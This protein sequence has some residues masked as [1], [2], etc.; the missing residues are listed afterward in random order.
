MKK[1]NHRKLKGIL[2]VFFIYFI[3][4][5]YFAHETLQMFLEL[6]TKNYV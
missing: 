1:K 6:Y 5:S 2:I 4:S 3:I